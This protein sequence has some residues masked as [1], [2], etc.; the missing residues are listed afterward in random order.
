MVKAHK[1]MPATG[2]CKLC[3]KKSALLESHVHPRLAYRRFAV[4]RNG[5]P[6]VDLA[7][8][9]RHQRQLKRRWFC[10]PCESKLEQ[11]GETPT[12]RWLDELTSALPARALYGPSL[13]Y[14]AVSLA[15]RYALLELEDGEPSLTSRRILS[16][17]IAIWRDFLKG[18]RKQLGVYNMHGILVPS[19][20]Q[21]GPWEAALG[22]QVSYFDRLVLSRT[23]P[24]VTFGLLNKERLSQH[25]AKQWSVTELRPAG[26]TISVV[27]KSDNRWATTPEMRRMLDHT[28]K[29]CFDRTTEFQ[30]S[31]TTPARL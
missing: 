1:E 18:A 17:P 27:R 16:K 4:E 8:L 12:A 10:R 26:G 23:G 6:F 5:S 30:K 9:T 28:G 13:T 3:G 25:E 24:L 2:F 15:Y 19:D 7:E 31:R 21:N 11:G 22:G 20:E 29:W 14:F